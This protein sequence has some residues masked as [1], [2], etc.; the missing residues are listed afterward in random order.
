MTPQELKALL[1]SKGVKE[2]EINIGYG[3]SIILD[4]EDDF[5]I[6]H[7][8]HVDLDYKGVYYVVRYSNTFSC[9]TIFYKDNKKTL[10]KTIGMYHALKS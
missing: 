7:R 10:S 6:T 4:I 5:K 3:Y 9:G 1:I 8:L 2:E